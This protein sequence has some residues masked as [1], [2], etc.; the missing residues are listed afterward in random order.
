MSSNSPMFPVPDNAT[1][2][3]ASRLQWLAGIAMQ[4]LILR[5]DS[6]PDSVAERE[7]IAFWSCRMAQ[8]MAATEQMSGIDECDS[9]DGSK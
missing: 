2:P 3:G 9:T 8:T 4:S 6:I 7:E 5:L 1:E